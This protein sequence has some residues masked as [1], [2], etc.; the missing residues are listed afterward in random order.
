MK[1]VIIPVLLIMIAYTTNH[2]DAQNPFPTPSVW[3]NTANF[4]KP[5]PLAPYREVDIVW[6]MRVWR[7]IN[8]K[9]KRNLQFYYP[10]EV[11]DGRISFMQM[12]IK[13]ME[14]NLITPYQDEEFTKPINYRDL[15]ASFEVTDS[16]EII[17]L[18]TGLPTIKAITKKLNPEDIY[19]IRIKEDWFIDKQKSYLE[20]RILGICP[21]LLVKDDNDNVKGNLP[22]FWINFDQ[23]RLLFANI[24]TFNPF[25]DAM[26]L[27]YDDLFLK[28]IFSSYIIKKS[29]VYNRSIA[30]Y[31]MGI[32]ALLE[33]EQIKDDI[34]N[35][36][37]D[38]WEY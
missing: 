7:V 11:A 24:Q 37:L 26:R 13:G 30:E 31:K 33:S 36:E 14:Y 4:I 34:F 38:L 21:V 10:T 12:I 28:R 6:S 23:A 18:D 20:V 5:V 29:N 25:N 22:M 16:V 3:E 1:K 19:Q 15:M 32:D 27:T 8:F 2:S 9:E 17:D 35:T